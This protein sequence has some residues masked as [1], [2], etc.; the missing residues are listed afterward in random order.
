MGDGDKL[1]QAIHFRL[2]GSYPQLSQTVVAAALVVQCRIGAFVRFLD[3]TIRKH[4]LNRTVER[5]GTHMQLSLGEAF[6]F[7]HDAVSMQFAVTQCQQNMEHC[8]TE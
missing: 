3:Q 1:R 6:D 4:L 8:R 2:R 5:A 7:L